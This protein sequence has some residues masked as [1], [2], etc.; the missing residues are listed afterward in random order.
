[1]L[2]PEREKGS[3]INA[4]V[5][6]GKQLNRGDLGRLQIQFEATRSIT[7]DLLEKGT[8]NAVIWNSQ[9]IP[10]IMVWTAIVHDILHGLS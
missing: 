3:D 1:M 8:L 9:Q 2:K 6:K 5:R 7:A 4:R 10:S